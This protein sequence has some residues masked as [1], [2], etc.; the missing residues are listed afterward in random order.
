MATLGFEAPPK[1]PPARY[2]W[3]RAIPGEGLNVTA[4]ACNSGGAVG[5][6]THAVATRIVTTSTAPRRMLA[7]FL[8]GEPVAPRLDRCRPESDRVRAPIPIVCQSQS[9]GG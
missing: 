2:T 1:A 6:D 4:T 3:I 5:T 8:T 9:R 7:S